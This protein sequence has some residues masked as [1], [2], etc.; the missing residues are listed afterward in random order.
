MTEKKK[1]TGIDERQVVD[2]LTRNTSFFN[3]H[4]KLLT[5]LSIPH[6]DG[7]VLS[8]SQK[9]V[10]V[11][12]EEVGLLKERAVHTEQK[13]GTL[14][15]IVDKNE[16]LSICLHR[17]SLKLLLRQE[18]EAVVSET[19]KTLRSQFPAN[20]IMIRLFPPYAELSK[21]AQPLDAKAPIL[22]TLLSSVFNTD[23]PDCGPFGS[24]IQKALFGNFA[25]RIQSA[26]VMPLRFNNKKI[27]L[28]LL[29]SSRSDTFIPGKG[30]MLLVQFGELIAVAIAACTRARVD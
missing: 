11:L 22:K 23:K 26:V 9:Q 12:R 29:G 2:F 19:V 5:E 14:M 28:L 8:L 24:V 20:Q 3:N 21:T 15:N 4:P 17:L 7:K 18:V 25:R 1:T 16:K 10:E 6:K 13:L 30:T 27:G